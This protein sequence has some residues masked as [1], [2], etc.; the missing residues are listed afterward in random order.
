MAKSVY[1]HIIDIMLAQTVMVFAKPV[2][3]VKYLVL[4][5]LHPF[6][7]ILFSQEVKIIKDVSV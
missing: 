1:L 3:N 2:S 6:C 4:V 5:G 7:K